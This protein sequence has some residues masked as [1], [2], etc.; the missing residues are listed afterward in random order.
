MQGF[1]LEEQRQAVKRRA[2]LLTVFHI[3]LPSFDSITLGF[4]LRRLLCCS[5]CFCFHPVYL[6]EQRPQGIGIGIER[7]GVM[8]PLVFSPLPSIDLIRSVSYQKSGSKQSNDMAYCSSHVLKARRV[9][10][11]I[12]VV[13][14]FCFCTLRACVRAKGQ[15]SVIPAHRAF[16]LSVFHCQ[17][18]MGLCIRRR[19]RP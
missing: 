11:C 18:C 16:H 7:P 19:E 15:Y 4:P 2:V 14:V 10:L 5:H 1:L 13:I 6:Q 3:S 17:F 8:L 9:Q 12:V